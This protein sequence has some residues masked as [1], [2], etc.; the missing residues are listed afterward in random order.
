M[1]NL[2]QFISDYKNSE[3]FKNLLKDNNIE[4]LMI[5]ITGSTILQ[6]ADESSDYDLCILIKERPEATSDVYNLYGRFNPHYAIYKPQQKRLHWIYNTVD[7]ITTSHPVSPL[8]NVG[9]A[10]FRYITDD[11]IIYKNPKYLLFVDTLIK[12]KDSISI[13]A[14]F[15]FVGSILADLRQLNCDRLR[16]IAAVYATLPNKALGHLYWASCILFDNYFDREF[17]MRVKRWPY[18]LLSQAEQIKV[19]E[20]LD[21]LELYV[22][23]CP[24][25][26][27]TPF[28]MEES[29]NG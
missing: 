24:F 13:N 15:S 18:E 6:S 21:A 11:F 1:S 4:V 28:K 17:M 2:Q 22:K 3:L 27:L 12:N 14:L 16:D 29:T 25:N 26:A 10:Q 9:W 20:I 23:T 5:W 19:L 8:D 7:E